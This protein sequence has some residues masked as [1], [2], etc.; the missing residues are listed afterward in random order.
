[1]HLTATDHLEILSKTQIN[2]AAY[3]VYGM[4]N[5]KWFKMPILCKLFY[6]CDTILIKVLADFSFVKTKKLIQNSNE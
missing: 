2:G 1:M 4:K 3:Y 6:K 5:S